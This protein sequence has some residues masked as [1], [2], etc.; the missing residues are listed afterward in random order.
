MN[1]T[2]YES[3]GYFNEMI[4]EDGKPHAAARPLARNLKTLPEGELELRQL[5][6]EHALVQAGI[7]F[8]VYSD[9]QGAS[10]AR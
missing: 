1:F 2:G 10:A 9:S 3:D 4:G 7:T 8:N 5:A 6:A